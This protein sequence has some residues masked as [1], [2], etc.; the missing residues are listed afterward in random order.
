LHGQ[1]PRLSGLLLPLRLASSSR[2]VIVPRATA[3]TPDASDATAPGTSS[4]DP[5]SRMLE[6]RQRRL[7]RR[8]E[9]E[10]EA[11]P[12]PVATSSNSKESQG[13][14]APASRVARARS[15]RSS[16]LRRRGSA[17][18]PRVPAPL[19][20]DDLL[21]E[22]EDTGLAV[23]ADWDEDE[24]EEEQQQAASSSKQTGTP[25][26]L[27][28][29]DAAAEAAELEAM[30]AQARGDNLPAAPAADASSTSTSATATT[31]S[32]SSSSKE[33]ALWSRARAE[34]SQAGPIKLSERNPMYLPVL[35]DEDLA[36]DPP[37]HKSGYVAVI[38][39]P[40]AGGWEWV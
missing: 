30:L 9:D 39:K 15:T 10:P 13:P 38:G 25:A 14:P 20:A 34:G 18:R 29:D 2:R 28:E 33:W 27:D 7:A 26:A 1:Q 5:R 40:N 4:G 17:V 19:T 31:S 24:G 11:A 21:D 22:D 36:A 37:G 6:R 23:E 35:T 32:S 16:R 12:E 8:A 3:E